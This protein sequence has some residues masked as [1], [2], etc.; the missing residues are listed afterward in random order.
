MKRIMIDA[1]HGGPFTGATVNGGTIREK[2]IT[3]KAASLLR[4]F[5]DDD[6]YDAYMTR[7]GDV[8]L[9]F[10]L[11]EDLSARAE[12]SNLM[13]V[14]CFVSIHCNSYSDPNVRGFEVFTTPG[15]TRAD[16]LA[17]EII[18]AIDERLLFVKIRSDLSDGDLDREEN[19]AVLRKTIAPAVLIE[20]GF[21][22]N[23]TDL[24]YLTND[25]D[26]TSMMMA[27]ARGIKSWFI[28]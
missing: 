9:N 10:D 8:S 18:K 26:L 13:E 12:M 27:I 7:N 14:D 2:D 24:Q 17:E 3:L 20:L 6:E 25:G 1:G 5:L 4:F 15:Q 22:S 19:F 28:P 23:E 21:L 16:P 11:N